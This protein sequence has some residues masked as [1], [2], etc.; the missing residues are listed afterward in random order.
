M[1]GDLERAIGDADSDP[2]MGALVLWLRGEPERARERLVGFQ[3]P[4][5]TGPLGAWM[6]FVKA[7]VEQDHESQLAAT[8]VLTSAAFDAEGMYY[9]AWSFALLGDYDGAVKSFVRGVNEG[10]YCFP[11]F[12]RESALDPIRMH[13]EF[14]E[15]FRKA[16]AKHHEAQRIFIEEGGPQL[17]GTELGD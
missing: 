11:T 5:E 13:P 4:V 7:I 15:A 1:R 14:Q 10:F 16:Q 3:M 6:R 2:G 17:L 12:K 8:R 9:A